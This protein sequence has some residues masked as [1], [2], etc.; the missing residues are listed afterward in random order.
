MPLVSASKI[1]READIRALRFRADRLESEL[2]DLSDDI[3]SLAT[4]PQRA[5]DE[6][7]GAL[8]AVL[9]ALDAIP[10]D[11]APAPLMAD[12]LARRA[13][14]REIEAGRALLEKAD[15]AARNQR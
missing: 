8:R 7:R 14:R 12:E 10:W 11:A 9:D 15:N 4:L 13:L 6:A 3:D 1:D 5:A 2:A